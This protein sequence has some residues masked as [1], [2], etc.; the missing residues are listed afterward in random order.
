MINRVYNPFWF[1]WLTLLLAFAV[2]VC[3]PIL[4]FRIES[5]QH[6]Q[7]G[8]LHSIICFVEFREKS[9]LPPKQKQQAVSFWA[10]ALKDAHLSPCESPGGN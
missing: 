8:A 4:F 1:Q 3:V 10:A 6:N 5:V 7:N 2:A 9:T